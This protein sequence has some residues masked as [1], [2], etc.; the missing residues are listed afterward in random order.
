M[1]TIPAAAARLLV[2]RGAERLLSPPRTAP[3]EASL[4][5]RLDE[6]GGEVVR[7][8]SRDGARL[9]GRW[10]PAEGPTDAWVPDRKSVV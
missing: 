4:G 7:L 10:L 8:R 3:E 1:A 9:A 6:L 5:P 2:G